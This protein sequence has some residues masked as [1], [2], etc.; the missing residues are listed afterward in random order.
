MIEAD[1]PSPI[2]FK[3]MNDAMEWER[4]AMLRPFREDFFAAITDEIT[5][6]Y[7]PNLHILDLGSGPGFLAPY[8]LSRIDGA[9]YT[10]LDFSPAMHELA[11]QRLGSVSCRNVQYLERNFKDEN[12]SDDIHQVDIVVTNQAVHE[13]RHKRYALTL[14]EQIRKLLN[15]EGTLLYCDH[16]CGSDAMSNSQLYMSRAEQ[17]E[18]L[19]QAGFIVKEIL[20][21]GGRALYRALPRH[22]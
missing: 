10:M 13:L 14:F 12:W 18:A 19:E 3:N 20:I 21:K 7:N 5:A 17:L 11:L 4:T 22:Q 1:V 15:P 9:H 16:Y 6:L 2:N 8:I